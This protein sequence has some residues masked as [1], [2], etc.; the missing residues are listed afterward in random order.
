MGMACIAC[1]ACAAPRAGF[2]GPGVVPQAPEVMLYFSHAIGGGPLA[3]GASHPTFGLRLQQVR[4]GANNADPESGDAMHRREL[5]NWQMEARPD[6]H[7]GDMRVQ[8]GRRVTYDITNARF[9][10]PRHLPAMHIGMPSFRNGLPPPLTGSG[11]RTGIAFAN[12]PPEPRYSSYEARSSAILES[13][14]TAW[15]PDSNVRSVRELAGAA[16]SAFSSFRPMPAQQLYAQRRSGTASAAGATA[17]LSAA[18]RSRPARAVLGRE[19]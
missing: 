9:G 8:L 15:A 13:R 19:N 2:F 16:F 11:A 3:G 18:L 1:I 12:Q 17:G 10:S 7:L 6:F 14:A 4:Q 5:L